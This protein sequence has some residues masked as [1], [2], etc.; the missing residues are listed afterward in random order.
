MPLDFQ[1]QVHMLHHENQNRYGKC[2]LKFFRS[3]G[4]LTLDSLHNTCSHDT[5][6]Y[7]D[8]VVYETTK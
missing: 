6:W 2:G 7:D 3:A 8:I 5:V 4:S 1:A